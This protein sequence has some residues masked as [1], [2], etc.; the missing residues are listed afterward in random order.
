MIGYWVSFGIFAVLIPIS[1]FM[2]IGWGV[3][4]TNP[5]PTKEQYA[6]VGARGFYYTFF[7][8]LCD[9]FYMAC[10]I[11]N[12]ICKYVFGGL[13]LIIIFVNLARAFT[14][15]K[16][17]KTFDRIGMVQ[18]FLVG[19]GLTIYL[20]YIVPNEEIRTIV[21]TVIAAVYGGFI[22]LVGVGWSIRKSDK[23]RK[24]DEIKKVRPI[25]SYNMLR[26]EPTLDIVVQK[27]CLFD[28][29]FEN[30]DTCE[31]N[32]EL[33]N[34]NLSPFEIKRIYHD[35]KRV[36]AQGN[37]IVLPG[38]KCILNFRFTDN[39]LHL[40]LELEDLLKNKHYYQL[41]VLTLGPKALSS[42]G[43][44]LH[45]VKAIKEIQEAEMNKL[46][47]GEPKYE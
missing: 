45:T 43:K 26:E 18:D 3:T 5:K 14:S 29:S 23:N 42:S 4:K 38:G 46:I 7:Y 13:I 25:F 1:I 20:I 19:T 40:F 27:I 47:R 12:L 22:G 31:V 10:F 11:N 32:V 9:L 2:F 15:P 44:F 21:I 41:R 28:I 24:E 36:E 30:Q 34:S 8:W 39:P 6:R 17:K 37:T 33:E 16:E 35:N